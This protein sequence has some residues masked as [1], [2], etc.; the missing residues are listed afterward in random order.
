[1]RSRTRVRIERAGT[2]PMMTFANW[3]SMT[4][5]TGMATWANPQKR[6]EFSRSSVNPTKAKKSTTSTSRR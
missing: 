5:I 3:V 1:M 2:I 6:E 4:L